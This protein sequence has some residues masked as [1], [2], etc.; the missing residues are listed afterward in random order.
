MK[1]RVPYPELDAVCPD[2]QDFSESKE[3]GLI[4]TSISEHQDFAGKWGFEVLTNK[5]ICLARF[6]YCS[7]IDARRALHEFAWLM[8]IIAVNTR[9]I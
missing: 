4:L 1:L 8:E 9:A 2:T 6:V 7:E 5:W 3:A